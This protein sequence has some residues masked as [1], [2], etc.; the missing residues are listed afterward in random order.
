MKQGLELLNGQRWG[1]QIQIHPEFDGDVS[2]FT[3]YQE[4]S[5]SNIENISL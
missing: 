5:I 4:V 1:K 3:C 2:L